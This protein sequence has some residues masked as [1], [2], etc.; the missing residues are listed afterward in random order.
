MGIANFGSF[1]GGLMR[2]HL[3]AT[4]EQ[5]RQ[6]D[7]AF[8]N[9]QRGVWRDDQARLKRVREG[10]AGIARPGAEEQYFERDPQAIL[11][12][13]EGPDM[14]RPA[15][16]TVTPDMYQERLAGLYSREGM[17]EL[18]AGAEDRAYNLR[19]RV[20]TDRLNERTDRQ[21][22][23]ADAILA[24]RQQMITDY[25]KDPQAFIS[26]YANLFN[27]DQFGGPQHAGATIALASTPQGTMAHYM[28]ADGQHVGSKLLNPQTVMEMING[29]TDAELGSTS[30]EQYGAAQ[31]RGIQRGQLAVQQGQLG[32][33]Q[34][35]LGVAQRNAATN[36]AYRTWLQ[37]RPTLTQDGSGRILVTDSSGSLLRTLGAPRPDPGAAALNR[38]TIRTATL[39][40]P[41]AATGKASKVPVNVVTQMGPDN[42]P[43]VRA[44]TMDGKQITDNKLLQQLAG[45]ENPNSTGDPRMDFLNAQ[46]QQLMGRM[47][48]DNYEATQQALANIRGQ[49]RTI[50]E[51]DRV[52]KLR[53][54]ERIPDAARLLKERYSPEALQA[55]GF[56]LDEVRKARRYTP[57]AQNPSGNKVGG[58]ATDQPME[59]S[60]GMETT[61]TP[62]GKTVYRPAGSDQWY[63]T[64]AEAERAER[65]GLNRQRQ[66]EATPA[67][68]TR[69]FE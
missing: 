31:T 55:F 7:Q 62:D 50:I 24:K 69:S 36:E 2:G 30:P 64:R 60:S 52:A 23:A 21:L 38:P 1:A 45:G 35:Q 65:A 4:E 57:T 54:E 27:S 22:A 3:A 63:A 67:G 58:S 46:E 56:T 49:R 19:Q 59:A 42:V 48:G 53:P 25:Q 34:G 41:D 6:E 40:M 51:T 10:I 66:P 61:K 15:T 44:Y 16:R 29:L 9:E 18:A 37:G 26:N 39:S 17:P 14:F 8:Q 12:G 5:R 32:V 11:E 28:G 33:A 13:A 43:T 47:T 20:R 68:L